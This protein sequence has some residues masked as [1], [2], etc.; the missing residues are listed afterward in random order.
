MNVSDAAHRD[1][2]DLALTL[3]PLRIKGALISLQHG[4][5][6]V[7]HN[8]DLVDLVDGAVEILCHRLDPVERGW[9]LVTAAQAADSAN[10]GALAE[11]VVAGDGPPIPAFDSVRAEARDWAAW[12]SGPEVRAYLAACWH[13]LPEEDRAA[14]LKATRRVAA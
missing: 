7:H 10:L 11:A 9:L 8:V 14:F 1:P 2:R 3:A 13:R 4:L 12:A 5:L 6:E